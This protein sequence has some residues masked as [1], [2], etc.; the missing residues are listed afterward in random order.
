MWGDRL[1]HGK[2]GLGSAVSAHQLGWKQRGIGNQPF[3][4]FAH[5]RQSPRI[6]FYLLTIDGCDHRVQGL[7]VEP[8]MSGVAPILKLFLDAQLAG[9][10]QF[11]R[12][13]RWALNL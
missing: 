1:H 7:A 12:G 2:Q 4:A 11:G 3:I 6:D 8:I 9:R 13:P 5:A 10:C